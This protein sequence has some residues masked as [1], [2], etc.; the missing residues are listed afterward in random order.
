MAWTIS[1]CSPCQ[2]SPGRAVLLAS[3]FVIIEETWSCKLACTFWATFA[4]PQTVID[5]FSATPEFIPFSVSHSTL[6]L[7]V[8]FFGWRIAYFINLCDSWI[9][10]ISSKWTYIYSLHGRGTYMQ[11]STY[12]CLVLT[13]KKKFQILCSG[14][15]KAYRSYER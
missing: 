15:N 12:V 6:L 14:K 1:W 13:S 11:I 10:Y 4:P 5:W 3:S 2:F 9:E 8:P 7:L